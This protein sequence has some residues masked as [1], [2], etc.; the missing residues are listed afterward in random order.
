MLLLLQIND[1]LRWLHWFD[2]IKNLVERT[3]NYSMYQYLPMYFVNAHF[4]YAN[5]NG[6]KL[7]YPS[8]EVLSVFIRE[9]S[10]LNKL[11]GKLMLISYFSENYTDNQGQER[12]KVSTF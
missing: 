5:K 6:F 7:S 11:V 10:M 4:L 8:A 3:H 9:F 12:R 2:S 1:G